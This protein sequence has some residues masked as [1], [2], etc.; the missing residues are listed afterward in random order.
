MLRTLIVVALVVALLAALRR[1]IFGGVSFSGPGGVGGRSR[2]KCS[3]CRHCRK[4]FD[5]GVLCG[6]GRSEVFKNETA[7]NNCPDHSRR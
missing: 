6:F 7:I 5:D 3:T 4:L 2:F 1:L